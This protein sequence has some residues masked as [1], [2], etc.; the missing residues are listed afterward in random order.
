MVNWE[1]EKCVFQMNSRPNCLRL[2][3]LGIRH[4][5]SLRT[6]HSPDHGLT[7]GTYQRIHPSNYTRYATESLDG[8]RLSRWHNM[9][10]NKIEGT[11]WVPMSAY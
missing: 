9:P 4:G 7:V 3:P 2:F 10:G 6:S 1:D 11:F 5:R 8:T